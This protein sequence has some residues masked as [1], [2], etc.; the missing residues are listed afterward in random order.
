MLTEKVFRN[1][2]TQAGLIKCMELEELIAI[3]ME[4]KVYNMC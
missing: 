2:I 1:F 4:Q 3:S